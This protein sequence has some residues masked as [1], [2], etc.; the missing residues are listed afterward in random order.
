MISLN[1]CYDNIFFEII[2]FC[3]TFLPCYTNMISNVE[4]I[5]HVSMRY[6]KIFRTFIILGLFISMCFCKNKAFARTLTF[7]GKTVEYKEASVKFTLDGKT[8]KGATGFIID[9]T[10]LAPCRPS[11][12]RPA[13]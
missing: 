3:D 9:G 7:D 13:R 4:R 1:H 6:F 12:N 8:V 2:Q 11:R 10:S 5:G